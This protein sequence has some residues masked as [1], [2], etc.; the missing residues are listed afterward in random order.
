MLAFAFIFFGFYRILFIDKVKKMKRIKDYY[1]NISKKQLQLLIDGKQ[2]SKKPYEYG[3]DGYN[4]NLKEP[5]YEKY[6]FW[7]RV[8]SNEEYEE[9]KQDIR[10]DFM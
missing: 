6:R 1:I 10:N 2:I 9:E 4:K 8:L 3:Y 7:I 5:Y